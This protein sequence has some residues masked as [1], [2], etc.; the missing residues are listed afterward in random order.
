MSTHEC[1]KHPKGCDAKLKGLQNDSQLRSVLFFTGP[2]GALSV[3]TAPF[4]V[5]ITGFR[6]V[7][8]FTTGIVPSS[9]ESGRILIS[10]YQTAPRQLI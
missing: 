1:A 6:K 5:R 7:Q 9:E 2:L 3:P 8:T 10:R 4:Y